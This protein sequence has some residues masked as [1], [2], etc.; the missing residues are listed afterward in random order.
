MPPCFLPM[1]ITNSALRPTRE[2][3]KG[4]ARGG[5]GLIKIPNQRSSCS[6]L[7]DVDDVRVGSTGLEKLKCGNLLERILA[8]VAGVVAMYPLQTHLLI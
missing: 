8:A 7:D 5:A 2:G 1:L 3:E 6:H 4:V